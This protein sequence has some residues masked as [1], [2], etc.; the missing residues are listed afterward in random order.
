[1][2][3]KYEIYH[4]TLGAAI[5]EVRKS[6]AAKQII[7]ED[8]ENHLWDGVRYEETQQRSF[9]IDSIKD[10]GTRKWLHVTVYRLHTGRYELTTYIL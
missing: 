2:N 4:E 6:I 3:L 5:Y 7:S 10:K 1:M 8:F 9:E